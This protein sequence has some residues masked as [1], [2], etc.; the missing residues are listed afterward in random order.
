[1]S[2][3]RD[4]QEAVI[5]DKTDITV[6]LR[7]CKVLAARLG[8]ENFN[9]W[10]DQELNG[11]KDVKSLPEYRVF[12]VFSKGH[13]AGPFGSGIKN[14]DIP[15]SCLPEK[16]RDNFKYRREREAISSYTSILKESK[17]KGGSAHAPW[18]PEVTAMVGQDI[19]QHMNCLSAWQVI[20]RN[21]IASLVDAVRN[22]VLN[23]V[24]EIEAQNPEAGE[25]PLNSNPI[26]Q[27]KVAQ[28]FNTYITGD[29]QNLAT[30]STNVTQYGQVIVK[31]NDIDSLLSYL[32]EHE[33][34]E[35][36]LQEL[37]EAVDSDKEKNP[38][39]DSWGPNV[40]GWITKMLGKASKGIWKIGSS[41]ATT[42]LT[43]AINNYYGLG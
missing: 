19:Y 17:G 21:A 11:Y 8:N 43:N 39:N 5:D 23:F 20:P 36:D 1:M 10:I 14:A 26:P 31:Q 15:I 30:A 16:M 4:I 9:N 38:S 24:L 33:I 13:F 22:R 18:P 3:L 29:V 32:R 25:A 42:L 6:V 34:E 37:K 2:L 27:E 7:K 40:S 35:T 41:V 28:I 12:E